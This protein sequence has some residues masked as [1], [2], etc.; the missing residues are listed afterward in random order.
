MRTGLVLGGGGLVGAAYEAGVLAALQETSGWDARTADI[1]LGT[2]AGSHTGALLRL[3]FGASDL[4]A[5]QTGEPLSPEGQLLSAKLDPL[6]QVPTELL[7]PRFRM[8]TRPLLIRAARHPWRTR[9]GLLAAAV[10]TGPFRSSAYADTLRRLAGPMWP[11]DPFWVIAAHL[12]LG[13]RVVFGREGSPDCDVPAAIAASCA[14][15]GLFVPVEICGERY[16]DGGIHSPTNADLLEAEGCDTVVIVSPMSVG[17]EAIRRRRLNPARLLSRALL[18][19]EVRRLRR[20]GVEVIVFQPGISDLRAMGLNALDPSRC[21][22][23][24]RAARDAVRARLQRTSFGG[25]AEQLAA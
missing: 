4:L 2:S 18:G 16:V 3:G 5:S 24:A 7:R 17:R 22:D 13:E 23:V 15:P 1:V 9:A 19:A 25:A 8:P 12:P 11:T 6:P 21:A 20:A 10:P 14:V